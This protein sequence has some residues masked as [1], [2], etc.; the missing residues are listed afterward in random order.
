LPAVAVDRFRLKAE[1]TLCSSWGFGL[2]SR[3]GGGTPL[4]PE[5]GLQLLAAL[6]RFLD[7][8]EGFMDTTIRLST[9]L[10]LTVLLSACE[11][12]TSISPSRPPAGVITPSSVTYTLYGA[13]SE[14]TTT[15]AVPIAGARVVDGSGGTATTD[16]NGH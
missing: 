4:Q 14:E 1:V 16:A 6:S 3:E 9:L 8:R 11:G 13:V 2:S 7:R 15:G 12:R 5:D 10:S